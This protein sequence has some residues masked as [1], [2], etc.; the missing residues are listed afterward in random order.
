MRLSYL[1]IGKKA[2]LDPPLQTQD[3]YQVCPNTLDTLFMSMRVYLQSILLCLL[4][5]SQ[6]RL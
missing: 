1:N 6:K 4:P 2:D 5:I 3:Q